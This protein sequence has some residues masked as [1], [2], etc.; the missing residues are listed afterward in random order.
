MSAFLNLS[1]KT[2]Q[3]APSNKKQ[4]SYTAAFCFIWLMNPTIILLAIS[5]AILPW[6]G[7]EKYTDS[8]STS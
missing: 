4:L 2:R 3:S 5:S 7:F 8:V 1:T 6:R